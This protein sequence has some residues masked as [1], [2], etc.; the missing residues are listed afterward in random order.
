MISRRHASFRAVACLVSAITAAAGCTTAVP[1]PTASPNVPASDPVATAGPTTAPSATAAA[2]VAPGEAW[3]VYQLWNGRA[4]I[5]LVRP[6]GSGDHPLLPEAGSGAETLHPDWSPDGL[7]IAFVSENAI[8]VS[9][10][11]GG[12]AR[13]VSSPCPDPCSEDY[14]A[15]SPDGTSIAYA[16]WQAEGN[17]VEHGDIVVLDLR[18][19]SETQVLMTD[20]PEYPAYP[21]WSPDGKSIVIEIDTFTD[22]TIDAKTVVA[23]VVATFDMAS[24]ASSLHRLTDPAMFAGYPDWSPVGGRIIF[25]TYDLGYRD[26]GSFADTSSPSDLYTISPDG[27]S[28]VQVTHNTSGPK[29]VRN[30]TASGPLSTQPTWSPDGRSVI[31]VQVEGATWPGWLIA[32]LRPD[33]T[34][35]APAPV[36][37]GFLGTHPRLRPIP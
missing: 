26:G 8:W 20:G 3:I 14:P 33:V 13:Q 32:S 36:P 31:F 11:D 22:S 19:G 29:L 12:N 27:S 34:G 25:S 9:D 24:G 7:N 37:D 16:R 2:R 30:G 1:Q 10:V 4:D 35:L 15:W 23:S 17:L 21:R 5:R 18:A 6:D 28:L